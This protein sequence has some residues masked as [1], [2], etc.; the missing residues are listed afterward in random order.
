M[1]YIV[2]DYP[3]GCRESYVEGDHNSRT[4][5]FC[6]AHQQLANAMTT[7]NNVVCLDCAWRGK[8]TELFAQACPV[9]DGRVSDD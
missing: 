8:E 6:A 9:C 2:N 3:C 7:N 4:K 1:S 5:S